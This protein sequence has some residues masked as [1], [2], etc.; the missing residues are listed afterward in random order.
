MTLAEQETTINWSRA[1]KTAS[2]WTTDPVVIRK[3]DEISHS[4]P[5][6]T[7]LRSTEGARAYIVPIRWVSIKKPRQL[8]DEQKEK[9]A[10]RMRQLNA[11][12]EATP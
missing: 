5:A 12:K 7:V 9:L 3:L 11:R 4:D 6:V 8:S 10:E 1:D 2:V